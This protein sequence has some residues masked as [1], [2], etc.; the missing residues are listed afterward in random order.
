MDAVGVKFAYI[1]RRSTGY[2]PEDNFRLKKGD[3]INALV[4]TKRLGRLDN[5]LRKI[6]K[7]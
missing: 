4:T 5:N 6:A 3:A 1:A 7:G 2:M